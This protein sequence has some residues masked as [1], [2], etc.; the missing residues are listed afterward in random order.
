MCMLAQSILIQ[1]DKPAALSYR[2]HRLCIAPQRTVSVARFLVCLIFI[3]VKDTKNTTKN[4]PTVS[5]GPESYYRPRF[6]KALTFF[7]ISSTRLN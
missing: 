2:N 7:Y 3:I 1:T 6:K 5:F 4:S